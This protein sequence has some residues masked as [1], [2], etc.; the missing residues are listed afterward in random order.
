L[1]RTT[2]NL[3]DPR[4]A[5]DRVRIMQQ[6]GHL[7]GRY[8]TRVELRSIYLCKRHHRDRAELYEIR[9]FRREVG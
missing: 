2:R 5:A 3:A 4:M 1:Q 7:G 8:E 6:T 9:A